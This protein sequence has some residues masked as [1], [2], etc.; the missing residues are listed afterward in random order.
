MPL[1]PLP[2]ILLAAA[3]AWMLYSS[4][5]YAGAGSIA[6]VAVLI[7]GTPLLLFRRTERTSPAG[8]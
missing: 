5:R 2:P 7:A 4:L 8:D 1:Y 3:A 6:G